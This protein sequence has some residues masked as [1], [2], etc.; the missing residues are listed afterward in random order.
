AQQWQAGD[1]VIWDNRCTLH[2][3]GPL[4][5]TLRRRMHRTQ[6]K[7]EAPPVAA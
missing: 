5:P 3:R 1:L 7:A 6:V 4:D 2:R